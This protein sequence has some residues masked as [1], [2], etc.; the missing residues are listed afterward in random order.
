VEYH[1][2]EV[3]G[4]GSPSS[5]TIRPTGGLETTMHLTANVIENGDGAGPLH[6]FAVGLERLAPFNPGPAHYH[7]NRTGD[8]RVVRRRPW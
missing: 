4:D 2:L 7:H 3:L 6:A 8:R 5:G 1:W